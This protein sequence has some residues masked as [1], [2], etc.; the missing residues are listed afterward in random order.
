VLPAGPQGASQSA[1]AAGS[2]HEALV[3]LF[4]AQQ[5]MLDQQLA[6]TVGQISA[7]DDAGSI[8]AGLSWGKT[9]A[10]GILTW[11]AND[12]F[13]A[14]PTPYV[15]PPIVNAWVPTPP[16][17]LPPQFTQFAN[18]TPFAIASPAQFMPG[19]PP[20]PRSA[21][22]ARDY[23][24]VQ[25]VGS[26]TSAVR[27]AEQSETATFWQS[28][29]PAAMWNRVADDLI[30]QRCG[31]LLHDAR[32]LALMN[33]AL[34]DATIAI[35][36]AKNA[37]NT[38]RAIT[39]I[40]NAGADGN[41]ATS[42]DPA[43]TPLLVTPPFQEYPAGHPGVSN[44]AATVLASFFGEHVPFTVTSAGMTGVERSFTDFPAAAEQVQ[45]A[46]VWGGIHFRF[47]TQV[48]ARMGAEVARYVTRTRLRPLHGRD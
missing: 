39:A 11:R 40:G 2:A 29:R 6:S 35:W 8:A 43:W 48:G 7:W 30:A 16:A 12:G 17:L 47:S 32:V 28:D 25:A 13:T 5:T 46:R 21:R 18:M 34:A 37:Y 9:V 42:A 31:S 4:P 41:P 10:D 15:P 24:E 20:S 38:W 1:A 33:L 23:D 22:Y 44:A 14:P 26:A 3:T 19:G 27:I 36:N 45:D